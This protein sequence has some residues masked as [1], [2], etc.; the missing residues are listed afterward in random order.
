MAQR[1][2]L[3][4]HAFFPVR[5]GVFLQGL[6]FPRRAIGASLRLSMGALIWRGRDLR[7]FEI[8][9]AV[10]QLFHPDQG[11]GFGITPE[12]LTY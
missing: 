10:A 5:S 6:F 8:F 2:S 7:G 4:A 9:L 11:F 3:A 1:L 12:L